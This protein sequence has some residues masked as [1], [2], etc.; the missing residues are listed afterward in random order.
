MT[1]TGMCID[2]HISNTV[3]AIFAVAL[4][5]K[6]SGIIFSLVS[7]TNKLFSLWVY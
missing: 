5:C 1:H 4:H 6:I 2:K 3:I 7:C